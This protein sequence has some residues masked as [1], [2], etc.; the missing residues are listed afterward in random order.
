MLGPPDFDIRD[1]SFKLHHIM[2]V[3]Q[4]YSRIY[5]GFG[6][7]EVEKW[8]YLCEGGH[9]MFWSVYRQISG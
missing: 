5:D 2:R 9:M 7:T 6:H 4:S 8:L 1:I 3:S